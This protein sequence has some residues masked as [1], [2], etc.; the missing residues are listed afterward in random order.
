MKKDLLIFL[1]ILFGF[2]I[3][4]GQNNLKINLIDNSSD[5][6]ALSHI[7]KITFDND[8]LILKT[9]T[10]TENSYHIDN[11]TSIT[12]IIDEVG[13][14]KFTETIDI[15]IFVNGFGEVVVETSHQIYQMTVF[16]LTGRRV[17]MTAQSK[18]NVNFL[19]TGI[20]ILQVVTDKG[21]IS[22]KFIKNR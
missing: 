1:A 4:Q 22:R 15:H 2:A 21:L 8:N 9:T 12:F 6:V 5:T 11:I 19:T 13:I 16:D 10:G 18:L 20:Y 7:Q 3:V 17:I 14:K